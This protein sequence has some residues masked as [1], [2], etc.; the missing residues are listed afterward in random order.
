MLIEG[1]ALS[2]M[3][4][5]SFGD[6]AGT[7]NNN[8]GA[9]MKP[10][11]AENHEFLAACA[12]IKPQGRPMTLFIDN[13]RLYRRPL[14]GAS[15]ADQRLLDHL[16]EGS[17]LLDLCATMPE[18]RFIIFT[19]LEDTP[20]DALISDRIPENVLAIHAVNALYH[21]HPK[22][23]PFPYGLQR[24]MHRR[25]RRLE[26][27][28]SWLSREVVPEN[29]LY[30]NH[31]VRTNPQARSGIKELFMQK[32]WARVEDRVID[33]P[34][35]LLQMK[36]HKFMICPI[37]NAM[38][39]HR[40]WETLYLRRV[41]VMRRNEYL[42]YLLRDF[43]VLFV[44]DYAQVT[45]DLLQSSEHLFQAAQTMDLAKLDLRRLF[46]NAVSTD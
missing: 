11:A 40:N 4:D 8:P 33:Y 16:M 23:H 13:I 25:D 9:F 38:D 7:A 32:S 12:R 45:L 39:C 41:P 17:S 3:C 34:A 46:S 5:Y 1:T 24:K 36:K 15:D 2:A 21:Q 37:G 42:E 6:Q 44:D 22:I 30:V 27:I 29:M 28:A 18:M 20:I 35:L 26:Q 31:N 19:H 43:P 10:A 14:R